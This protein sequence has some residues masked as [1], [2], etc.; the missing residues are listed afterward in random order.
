MAAAHAFDASGAPDVSKYDPD[1][2]RR[3][4]DDYGERGQKG[5][6]A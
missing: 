4:Y 2:V 1:Y 6:E 5:S 3:L